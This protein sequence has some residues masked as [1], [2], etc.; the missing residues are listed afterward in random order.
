MKKYLSICIAALAVGFSLSHA[1]V[2]AWNPELHFW[3]AA[4]EKKLA[5]VKHLRSVGDG[6][7]IFVTGGSSTAFA[8]DGEY[9]LTKFNLPIANFG[10]HAGMGA[11]TIAAFTL[12]QAKAGDTILLM[13][14]PGLLIRKTTQSAFGT[15]FET[16]RHLSVDEALGRTPSPL[17][18]VGINIKELRPGA[19][20]L[21]SMGG[22]ALLGKPLYRYSVD[23]IHASGLLTTDVRRN[24]SG[25]SPGSVNLTAAGEQLLK[26]LAT[27]AQEKNV[28]LIYALP[29]QYFDERQA[30]AARAARRNLLLQ[31]AAYCPTIDD[32]FTGVHTTRED[33]ADTP[34]HLVQ[35]TATYRT[36]VLAEV[37]RQ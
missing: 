31:I 13:M 9:A 24:I 32:G 20:N 1:Y 19:A 3:L 35:E 26:E 18:S 23:D 22:K 4:T 8:I 30:G 25:G 12:D 28:N 10:L 36:A 6:S 29:W 15:Q 2:T 34:L 7:V 14:E 16:A 33:F 17:R 11:E 27:S 21:F 5:W 37:L